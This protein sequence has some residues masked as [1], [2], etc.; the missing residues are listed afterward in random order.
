MSTVPSSAASC[1]PSA[2]VSNKGANTF[3][4]RR[5]R[6]KRRTAALCRVGAEPSQQGHPLKVSRVDQSEAAHD[7]VGQ[8]RVRWIG[9]YDSAGGCVWRQRVQ[10]VMDCDVCAFGIGKKVGADHL[11]PGCAQGVNQ[12]PGTGSG[13]PNDADRKSRKDL[14]H[15]RQDQASIE[16]RPEVGPGTGG[17]RPIGRRIFCS[18][19]AGQLYFSSELFP[20]AD[21]A[22][23]G[24]R[25]MALS[26]TTSGRSA[27]TDCRQSFKSA[28]DI[29]RRQPPPVA[30]EF[31]NN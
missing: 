12:M 5:R 2:A 11:T 13:L 28:V 30:I 15:E 27:M 29:A 8:F 23:N 31:R 7:E 21:R 9:N 18:D 26:S 3:S 4:T 1:H 20:L 10:E 25:H 14:I 24:C 19:A 17:L 22:A 6:D 16:C